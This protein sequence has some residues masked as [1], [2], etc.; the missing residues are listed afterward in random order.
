VVTAIEASE[1]AFWPELPRVG[2][3]PITSGLAAHISD[4]RYFYCAATASHL[5]RSNVSFIILIVEHAVLASCVR[6]PYASSA[7]LQYKMRHEPDYPRQSAI[8][9]AIRNASPGKMQDPDPVVLQTPEEI[10]VRKLLHLLHISGLGYLLVVEE[11]PRSGLLVGNLFTN[12][13]NIVTVAVLAH[14]V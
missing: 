2:F 4:G 10:H 7:P 13:C 3:C 5:I 6:Y 8:T 11:D 9:S 12:E 14:L 1:K